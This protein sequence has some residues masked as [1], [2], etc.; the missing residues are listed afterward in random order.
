MSLFIIVIKMPFLSSLLISLYYK[1][2]NRA[3][4]I[5]TN[6]FTNRGCFISIFIKVI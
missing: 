1:F 5:K 4:Y 2:I 6:I 3:F